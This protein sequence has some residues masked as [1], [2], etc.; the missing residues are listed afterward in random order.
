MNHER[1]EPRVEAR[2]WDSAGVASVA[3]L[4]ASLSLATLAPAAETGVRFNRDIRPI[5]ADNCF[6]CHGPDNNAR[7]AALRLDTK[8]GLF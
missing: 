1:S 8:D 2:A 4:A 5:L 6:A 7:K 3:M